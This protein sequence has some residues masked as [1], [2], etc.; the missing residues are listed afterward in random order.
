MQEL[1]FYRTCCGG[2]SETG[3]C[4]LTY[5]SPWSPFGG[6]I[7][8][9]VALLMVRTEMSKGHLFQASSLCLVFHRLDVKPQLLLLCHACLPVVMLK[10][11]MAQGS[12][13]E[14]QTPN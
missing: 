9:S 12:P 3:H 4:R 14:W 10:V 5:L 7:L 13:S 11:G 2:L 1:E 8:G 6:T